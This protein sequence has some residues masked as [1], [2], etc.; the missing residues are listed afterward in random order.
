MIWPFFRISLNKKIYTHRILNSQI[1]IYICLYH[2]TLVADI[3][4]LIVVKGIATWYTDLP[5]KQTS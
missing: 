1:K 3:I 5:H 2:S 4:N